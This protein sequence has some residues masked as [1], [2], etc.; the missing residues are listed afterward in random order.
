MAPKEALEAP[1]SLT[2]LAAEALAGQ[3]EEL[4]S[5]PEQEEDLERLA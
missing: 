2:E 3:R 1:R 4:G 5:V